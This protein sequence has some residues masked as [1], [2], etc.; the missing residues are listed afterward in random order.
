VRL[1]GGAHPK[2]LNRITLNASDTDQPQLMNIPGCSS[3]AA[4][5]YR[6]LSGEFT[7]Q[8]TANSHV[9]LKFNE[10]NEP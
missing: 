8:H 10:S 6:I 3:E 5:D 7:A 4:T 9:E 1:Y 2:I